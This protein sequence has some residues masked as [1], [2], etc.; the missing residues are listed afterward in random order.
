MCMCAYIPVWIDVSVCICMFVCVCVCA[1][2]YIYMHT[3][4]TP[5]PSRTHLISYISHLIS[6]LAPLGERQCLIPQDWWSHFSPLGHFVREH[7]RVE[8]PQDHS[9]IQ[10][11]LLYIQFTL[12]SSF[13]LSFLPSSLPPSLPPSFSP[14]LPPYF[15]RLSFFCTLLL[16][17]LLFLLYLLTSRFPFC[18]FFLFIFTTSSVAPKF[19]HYLKRICFFYFNFVW[20]FIYS[21][22]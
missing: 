20:T 2:R 5:T 17:S 9:S 18:S 1:H 12:P 11:C 19:N 15:S 10:V 7:V 3:L 16:S 13:P 14:S 21:V 4:P 6:Y 22:I 8:P